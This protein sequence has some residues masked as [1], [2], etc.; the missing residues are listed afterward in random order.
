MTA[1]NWRLW[2]A[3]AAA[4][5]IA[6]AWYS[7][8]GALISMDTLR[9]HRQELTQ[10]VANHY[11][12]AAMIY[13]AIYIVA[14]AS[15]LPGA[16]FLTLAGGFFFGPSAGTA[17]T[18]FAATTGATLIFLFARTVCGD[19]ILN[20]CGE[21]GRRLAANIRRNAWPYLLALRLV[22][23]FPFFLAN[24]IFAFAGVRR[25]TFVWTTAIGILPGTLVFSLS[26][27]GLGSLLEQGGTLSACSILTPEIIA[28]LTGLAVLS[29]AAIPLRRYCERVESGHKR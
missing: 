9:A 21:R 29:L 1:G 15:S 14:V 17:F 2:L 28:G 11:W 18:V 12:R 8:L 3:L 26:G 10:F 13:M 24:L 4:M 23:I 5:L 22:P 25:T 27:G 20:R 19:A 7:G 16:V 6:A